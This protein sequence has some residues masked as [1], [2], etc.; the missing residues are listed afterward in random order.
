MRHRQALISPLFVAHEISW[1]NQ[2]EGRSEAIRGR[3]GARAE[4]RPPPLQRQ[5]LRH[6][7]QGLMTNEK[8]HTRRHLFWED[9]FVAMGSSSVLDQALRV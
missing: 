6:F 9:A 2:K 4:E 5:N 8:H 3:E 7:K 1:K